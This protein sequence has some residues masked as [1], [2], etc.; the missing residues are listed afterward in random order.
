MRADKVLTL[1]MNILLVH[2]ELAGA[3]AVIFVAVV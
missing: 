1:K 2:L 3:W